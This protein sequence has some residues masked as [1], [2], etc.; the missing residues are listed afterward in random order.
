MMST[1]TGTAKH[2]DEVEA[3]AE[4]ALVDVEA[5]IG[6]NYQCGFAGKR[7]LLNCGPDAP[8]ESV[9]LLEREQ[10]GIPIIVVMGG[11]VEFHRQQIHVTQARIGK[12]F[13]QL[14]FQFVVDDIA[15]IKSEQYV[16]DQPLGIFDQA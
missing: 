6:D 3:L 16:C 13:N 9:K 10:V 15:H 14:T 1:A 2:T 11:V 5:M 8:N 12:L 4:N 7:T